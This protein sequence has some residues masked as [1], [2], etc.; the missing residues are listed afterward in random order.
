MA[1]PVRA[2]LIQ[3]QRTEENKQIKM[4]F[5]LF[6]KIN[7]SAAGRD[8]PSVIRRHAIEGPFNNC[9][10]HGTQRLPVL[11]PSGLRYISPGGHRPQ[12]GRVSS[13]AMA[14]VGNFAVTRTGPSL[15]VTLTRDTPF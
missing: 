7:Y 5:K 1:T 2:L 12:G 13:A 6:A 14:L 3:E 10:L 15:R 9:R 8:N 4:I 11:E